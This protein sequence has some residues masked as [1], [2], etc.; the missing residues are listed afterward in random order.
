MSSDVV[1]ALKVWQAIEHVNEY[2]T[3]TAAAA[4]E[5]TVV[6]GDTS[7]EM[8]CAVAELV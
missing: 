4:D 8:Q 6:T 7:T 3:R 5:Q 1:G 2:V